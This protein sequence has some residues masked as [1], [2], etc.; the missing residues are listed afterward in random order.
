LRTRVVEVG[1]SEEDSRKF[2]DK[3]LKP[4]LPPGVMPDLEFFGLK[5]A[6]AR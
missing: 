5:A 1:E 4:S 3:N 6:F 2:F